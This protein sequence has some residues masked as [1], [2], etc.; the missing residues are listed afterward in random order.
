MVDLGSWQI[1][2]TSQRSYRERS[3]LGVVLNPPV[4]D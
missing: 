3:P 1:A 4:E 2:G